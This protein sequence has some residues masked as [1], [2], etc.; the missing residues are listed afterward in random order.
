M[1]FRK[2]LVVVGFVLFSACV[3]AQDPLRFEKEILELIKGDSVVNTKNLILFTGSSSIR[4]WPNLQ[5]S[6]PSKNVLNRGFGGSEMSDLLYYVQPLILSYKPKTIFIYEGDNDLNAGR[7]AEQIL[8][9]A[10]SLLT[11]IRKE[12]P[13]TKIIFIAAKP[14]EARWHLKPTYEDFNTKLKDWT[15]SRKRVYFADVWSPMLDNHGKLLP[16][17]LQEDNL[18]MTEKGYTIWTNVLKRFL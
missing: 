18:H 4:L 14:S 1:S 6:F 11:G 16:D 8:I 12:L 7:T 9:F 2:I 5:V 3:C 13:K 15:K 10:D 17:L